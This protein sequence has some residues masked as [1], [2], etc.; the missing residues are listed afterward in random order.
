MATKRKLSE[1]II[2]ILSGG[3]VRNDSDIDEREV[4]QAIETPSSGSSLVSVI[5]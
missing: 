5:I 1:Q 2:R 3:D 4:M